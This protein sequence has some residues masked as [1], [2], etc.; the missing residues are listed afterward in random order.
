MFW[1]I[2]IYLLVAVATMV[3]RLDSRGLSR[4]AL[5]GLVWPGI[6]LSGGLRQMFLLVVLVVM[7][8]GSMVAQPDIS[9]MINHTLSDFQK[10]FPE[11]KVSGAILGEEIMPAGIKLE[12]ERYEIHA[13]LFQ[14]KAGSEIISGIHLFLIS[15]NPS[16]LEDYEEKL[17]KELSESTFKWSMRYDDFDRL[18]VVIS[19]DTLEPQDKSD[20]EKRA[21][22]A[23][24]NPTIR[25]V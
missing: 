14:N 15:D 25:R 6:L 7:L 24:N 9:G 13:T 11:F 16:I 5:A 18:E 23:D 2:A 22:E 8:G 10:E 17:K 3:V 20:I 19:R 12:T 21:E 4:S 1:I